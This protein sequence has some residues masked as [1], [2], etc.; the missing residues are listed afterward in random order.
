MNLA[1]IMTEY[2]RK[3]L[4][5]ALLFENEC[6]DPYEGRDKLK[7]FLA[8]KHPELLENENNKYDDEVEMGKC[9]FLF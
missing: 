4:M 6:D 2:R 7:I 1:T 5:D 8:T 9:S 3:Q